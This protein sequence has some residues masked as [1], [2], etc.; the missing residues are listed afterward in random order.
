LGALSLQAA[1]RSASVVAEEIDRSRAAGRREALSVWAAVGERGDA[2]ALQDFLSAEQVARLVVSLR[3]RTLRDI[4]IAWWCPGS[5][6]LD[7]FPDELVREV[8]A[9]FGDD[10]DP[11]PFLVPRLCWV[12]RAVGDEHAAP[13]LTVLAHVALHEGDGTL[14]RVALDRA[15]A[16]DPGYTLAGLLSQMLDLGIRPDDFPAEVAPG[17]ATGTVPSTVVPGAAGPSDE[18]PE[19]AVCR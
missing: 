4:V 7:A 5:L 19:E 16:H 1:L 18:G 10:R 11:R 2:S 9:A 8:R 17:D 3:D 14:A 6:A 13:V 12:A 15:L